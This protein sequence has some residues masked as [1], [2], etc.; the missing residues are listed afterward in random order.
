VISF[1]QTTSG[2]NIDEIDTTTTRAEAR[3]VT[4]DTGHDSPIEDAAA[5]LQ[6][7]GLPAS[8]TWEQATEA[9]RRLVADLTPGPDASHSNVEL[10]YRYLNEVNQAYAS[11]RTLAAA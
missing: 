7:L 1:R 9:H 11:L 6:A 4:G 8:A 2:D 10:A 5:H 3:I